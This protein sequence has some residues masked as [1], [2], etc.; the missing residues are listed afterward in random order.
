M[1][2]LRAPQYAPPGGAW[3]YEVEGRR[4]ESRS[5]LVDVERLV[6][7]FLEAAEIPVPSDLRARIEDYICKRLPPGNC[8]GEGVRIPGSVAP[9]FFEVLK[10]LGQLR[11]Q[12]LVEARAAEDRAAVCRKCANNN[13]A[14]CHSCNGL[15]EQT[16]AAVG[17]RRV[18]NLPYL[19]VC[20]LYALPTYGLVWLRTP[21]PMEGLP[22]NCWA[23]GPMA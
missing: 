22:D 7:S 11:G 23:K 16:L 21:K 14:A 6:V 3:F 13:F 5:S 19:G 9:G 18:L 17:G 1:L 2:A 4:F 8:I 12:P 20:L 15:R 10:N